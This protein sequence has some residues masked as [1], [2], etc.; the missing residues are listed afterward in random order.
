MGFNKAYKR[1]NEG[2]IRQ[3]VPVKGRNG[4]HWGYRLMDNK[5]NGEGKKE[6]KEDAPQENPTPKKDSNSSFA[7]RYLQLTELRDKMT[8]QNSTAARDVRKRL[9]RLQGV[10]DQVLR[11]NKDA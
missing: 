10:V 2:L 3:K 5:P 7:D 4:Y 9:I 1:H 8:D 11:N 6:I